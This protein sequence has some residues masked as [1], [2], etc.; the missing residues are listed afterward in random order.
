[1]PEE[2]PPNDQA[3]FY[4]LGTDA[5]TWKRLKPL[6]RTSRKEPTRAEQLLWQALRGGQ[7]GQRFRRQHAILGFV[8]DFVCLETKLI[9]EVDGQVHTDQGD[10][11]AQRTELLTSLGYRVIRFA[12]EEVEDHLPEVLARIRKELYPPN[13]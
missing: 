11:D 7:L 9:V 1:M 6:A 3:P 2:P 10:Y 13:P 8:A 5:G 4:W 12:N